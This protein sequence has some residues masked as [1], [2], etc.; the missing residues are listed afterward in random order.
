MSKNYLPVEPRFFGCYKYPL[1]LS[2][3]ATRLCLWLGIIFLSSCSS[4]HKI[5]SSSKQKE[6]TIDKTVIEQS[7][8]TQIVTKEKADTIISTKADTATINFFVPSDSITVEQEIESGNLKIKITSKPVFVNGI[9][10]GNTITATAIKKKEDLKVVIDKTS[11]TNIEAQ[12][13]KKN[14][15]VTSKVIKEDN[16]QVDTKLFPWTWIIVLFLL[17]SVIARYIYVKYKP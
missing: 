7:S 13:K 16:K 6:N 4:S 12:T 2:A 11:T 1:N 14:D 15:I 3:A 10:K 17:L 8:T 9:K 5:K